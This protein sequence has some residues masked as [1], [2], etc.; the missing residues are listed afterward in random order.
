MS[1]STKKITITGNTTHV[2]EKFDKRLYNRSYRRQIKQRLG[3]YNAPGFDEEQPLLPLP[4]EIGTP[5]D[6]DKDG[7]QYLELN[8]FVEQIRDG[9]LLEIPKGFLDKHVRTVNGDVSQL[10]EDSI[11]ALANERLRNHMRK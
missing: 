11:L 6:F 2:S 4:S 10:S 9:S 3:A 5:Y 8:E 1:K 7:K